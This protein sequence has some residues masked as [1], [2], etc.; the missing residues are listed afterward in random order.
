MNKTQIVEIRD[1]I[2]KEALPNIAFDGWSWETITHAAQQCGHNDKIAAAVFPGKIIDVLDGFSDMADR[3]MLETLKS[4][5]PDEMRI[6]DR[7]RAG[8]LARF[9]FLQ[10]HKEAVRES[11][12][13]WMIPTRKPRAVKIIWRSADHIWRW[14]GDAA[15]DYNHYTKRGLLSGILGSTM[16]VWLDDSSE[17]NHI[18]KGFLDRRI[19]DVLSIGKFVGGFK[20]KVG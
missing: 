15:T 4:Q 12:S 20:K 6:R 18:T 14:A 11:V 8:V 1:E 5:S 3:A 10:A 2:I 17:D 19:D 7:V 13:F 16:L 9:D